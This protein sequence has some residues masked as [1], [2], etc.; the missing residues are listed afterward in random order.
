MKNEK[1][2][3][4]LTLDLRDDPSLIDKYQEWHRPGKIWPEIPQGIREVG[5]LDM[6]IYLLGT[7]LFMILE[8]KGNFDFDSQMKKLSNL[9]RQHEW[10]TLMSTFQRTLPET[11]PSK[12]WAR[13]KRIFRLP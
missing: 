3:Y 13:M 12:K 11:E 2:R 8:T 4:C 7:R 10:E 5:I 9:P 6:E 1:Q